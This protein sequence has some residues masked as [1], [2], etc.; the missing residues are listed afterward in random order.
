MQHSTMTTKNEVRDM[1]SP[2][3]A[4]KQSKIAL[5]RFKQK[6]LFPNLKK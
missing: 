3:V 2:G 1:G 6:R 4:V 5:K